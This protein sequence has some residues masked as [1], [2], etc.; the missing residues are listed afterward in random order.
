MCKSVRMLEI[1]GRCAKSEWLSI[2]FLE[3]LIL[4]YLIRS[5]LIHP[6]VP[7]FVAVVDIKNLWNLENELAFYI[8][9]KHPISI[10]YLYWLHVI[11]RA[12]LYAWRIMSGREGSITSCQ[13][14]HATP[15]C[16]S[17]HNI[18]RHPNISRHLYLGTDHQKNPVTR[19]NGV[20]SSIPIKMRSTAK[21]EN[22]CL[23]CYLALAMLLFRIF[24]F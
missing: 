17:S 24:Y 12:G 18:S 8:F 16:T 1:T 20:I 3:E 22:D 9:Y 13:L 23:F 14:L 10:N 5:G 21:M 19:K 6:F 2:W 11:R 4:L 7:T 15:G